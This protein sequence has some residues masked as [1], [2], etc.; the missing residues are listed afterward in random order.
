MSVEGDV[1]SNGAGGNWCDV[2]ESR[3][4]EA[5]RRGH[6]AAFAEVYRRLVP[7]R[8]RMARRRRVP[9]G[10]RAI[11]I[12]DYVED[13]L[14][15][16]L[17]GRRRVP[18]PLGAYLATGFRRRPVAATDSHSLGLQGHHRFHARRPSRRRV[19]GERSGREDKHDHRQKR[20]RVG[21]GDVE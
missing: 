9:D 18:S 20:D 15:P 19:R 12:M 16:V 6:H 11:L 8:T 21:R 7:L 10:E 5:M 2:K 14:M 13:A 3:L 4:F 17:R 1:G